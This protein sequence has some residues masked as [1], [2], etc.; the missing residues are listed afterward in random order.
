MIERLWARAVLSPTSH[1]IPCHKTEARVPLGVG[2]VQLWVEGTGEELVVLRLLGAR[3]RA[4]LA[5]QDPAD[6]LSG[7]PSTVWALNPPGFGASSGPISIRHYLTA[8]LAAHDFLATRYPNARLWVYGKSIGATAAIYVAAHRPVSALILKNTIDVPAIARRRLTRW[9]AATVPAELHP[10]IWAPAGR[11]PALFVISSDDQIARPGSQLRIADLYGAP[12]TI[13]RVRGGHDDRTLH[14]D[15]EVR[16]TEAV[17]ALSRAS[18]MR[19]ATSS[20]VPENPLT[21]EQ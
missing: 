3:G 11:C 20:S 5:T 16:Y 19:V 17:T 6:R 9:I 4:E 21:K 13:L 10:A 8:A 2:W 1:D 14:A 15:D 12:H 18:G 7:V